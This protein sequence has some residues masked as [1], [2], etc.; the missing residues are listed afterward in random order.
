[1]TGNSCA[2][3]ICLSIPAAIELSTGLAEEAWTRTSTSFG[4]SVGAG[5]SSRSL[6]GVSNESRVMAFIASPFSVK[7]VH[8]SQSDCGVI[9]TSWQ[10]EKY[11]EGKTMANIVPYINFA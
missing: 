6:G 8:D 5:R 11:R 7:I 10:G 1:M 2:M 4:A 9:V 3:P